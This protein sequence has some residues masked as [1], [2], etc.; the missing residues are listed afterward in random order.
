MAE[1][2]PQS[3]P[4]P[5]PEMAAEDDNDSHLETSDAEQPVWLMKC[6]R[7]VVRAMQH[8]ND[9]QPPP[10]FSSDAGSSDKVGKLIVSIDPLAPENDCSSTE[11]TL[12]LADTEHGKIPKCYKMDMSSD[13]VPMSVF[14]ESSQ[15]E[16]SVEGKIHHKFDM[17]PHPDYFDDY[18]KLSRERME[19]SMIKTRQTKRI[20]YDHDGMLM[21]PGK[22]DN[23][24]MPAT[25]RTKID[26][27]TMKNVM[28]ELFERQPKWTL[29]QLIHV[30]NQPERFLKEMLRLLCVYNCKGHDQGIYELK[31]EYK[32]SD[33]GTN[34]ES[35]ELRPETSD[36]GAD[37]LSYE[38]KPEDRSSEDKSN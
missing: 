1:E 34:Q 38:L 23:N 8:H 17:K 28:F 16:V 7:V 15:G 20:E 27:E 4:S 33:K 21:M 24:K 37:Q 5:P 22:V 26:T 35:Y 25:R 10:P 31:P 18:A 19:K 6:P 2:P 12:E 36:K 9:D 13:F 3:T 29:K 30:T 32:R 14:S 11:F